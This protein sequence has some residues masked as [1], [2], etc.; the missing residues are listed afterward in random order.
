MSHSSTSHAISPCT[1]TDEAGTDNG[2]RSERVTL[3]KLVVIGP[4][5]P[6]VHGVVVMTGQMLRAL[7]ELDAC[8]GYLDTRDPRPVTT[9]GRLDMRNV[10][11]GLR[12]VWQLNRLLARRRN[13]VGVHLCISQV[14]W[15][16]LR[17][18]VLVGLTRARRRRLYVHLHGG[19][20]AEFYRRSSPQM[21]WL[22]RVVMRQAYQSWVLTPTLR[23]QFVG[24]VAEDRVHCVP[25]VV[26]DPLGGAPFPEA[27]QGDD[28]RLRILYLANLLPEK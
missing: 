27:E 17:D 6:P 18:A 10:M 20:L 2:K 24:L 12:H 15:G 23:S 3:A 19:L 16:C 13:T 25:N 4:S 9:I 21:R 14:R 1:F 5:P 11:L 26:D 7:H 8:A 22:I 28:A